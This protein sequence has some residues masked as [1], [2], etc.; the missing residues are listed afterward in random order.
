MNPASP[1]SSPHENRL[2]SCAG[3]LISSAPLAVW[4]CWQK[5][6]S[7]A[8]LA[9]LLLLGLT[10][11]AILGLKKNVRRTLFPILPSIRFTLAA[12]AIFTAVCLFS[13]IVFSCLPNLL[14][15]SG[16]MPFSWIIPLGR[17]NLLIQMCSLLLLSIA[18]AYACLLCTGKEGKKLFRK[19]EQTASRP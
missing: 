17:L 2:I 9:P 14:A 13:L 12:S 15:A 4:A 16:L 1:A 11:G 6:P 5:M 10:A 7:I 19:Q 3:I 8:F 18:A